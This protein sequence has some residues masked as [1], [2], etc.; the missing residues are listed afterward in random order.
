MD[1]IQ[2]LKAISKISKLNLPLTKRLRL[3]GVKSMDQAK[4]VSGD[5]ALLQSFRNYTILI[6]TRSF[7]G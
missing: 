7:G 3:A 1:K 5:S 4:Y 6:S 2:L